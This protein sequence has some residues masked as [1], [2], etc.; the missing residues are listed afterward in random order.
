[1]FFILVHKDLTSN[2]ITGE[3]FYVFKCSLIAAVD[4]R[5]PLSVQWRIRAEDKPSPPCLYIC[6]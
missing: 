3:Q 2:R 1:M 4:K 6:Y 5:R